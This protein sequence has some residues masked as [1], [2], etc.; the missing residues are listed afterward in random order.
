MHSLRILAVPACVLMLAA[1]G[2]TG[3][4]PSAIPADQSPAYQWI[5]STV[6]PESCVPLGPVSGSADCACYD[7][8]SYDNVRGKASTNL[9]ERALAQ[10]PDSDLIEVSTV[11]LYLNSAVA[12]GVAYKC[13][14]S[15]QHG[16]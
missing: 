5:S 4:Q 12:R 9:R 7:K 8:M 2:C 1:S 6:P 13:L 3:L 11:E 10:Y 16:F 14:A 15:A